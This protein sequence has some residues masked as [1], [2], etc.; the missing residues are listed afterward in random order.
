MA[1]SSGWLKTLPVTS[2]STP[3][4]P[5]TVA[6]HALTYLPQD[7]TLFQRQGMDPW[8]LFSSVPQVKVHADLH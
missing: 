3:I 7:S 1:V 4:D 6:L 8:L 2:L 5:A